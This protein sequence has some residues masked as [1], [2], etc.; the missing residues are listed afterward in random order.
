MRQWIILE[1]L[2]VLKLVNFCQVGRASFIFDNLN[3]Y[4]FGNDNEGLANPSLL[5]MEPSLDFTSSVDTSNVEPNVA[6][7][8]V[9]VDLQP[10]SNFDSTLFVRRLISLLPRSMN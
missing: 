4:D 6:N 8:D 2:W 5:A 9:F 7:D 10:D 3:P 1:P